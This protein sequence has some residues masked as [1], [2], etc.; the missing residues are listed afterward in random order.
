MMTIYKAVSLTTLL[1]TCLPSSAST[2]CVP[3]VYKDNKHNVAV[4][5]DNIEN[6]PLGFKYLLLDGR[7]GTTLSIAKP[8]ECDNNF[9]T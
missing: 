7:F 2:E 4:I 8:C 5:T 3:G 9:I 1:A 6:P